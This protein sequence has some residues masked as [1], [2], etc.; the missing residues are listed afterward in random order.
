MIDDSGQSGKPMSNVC[1]FCGRRAYACR[2][3]PPEWEELEP[4]R[5]ACPS[6]FRILR[7]QRC[8]KGLEPYDCGTCPR[9]APKRQKKVPE[10]VTE[11]GW[12]QVLS[13]SSP[14]S[15]P[16]PEHAGRRDITEAVE[17]TQAAWVQRRQEC[18]HVVSVADLSRA[19]QGRPE[20]LPP[21]HPGYPARVDDVVERTC[22]IEGRS[23]EPCTVEPDPC[24]C[25]R[26]CDGPDPSCPEHGEPEPGDTVL[27]NRLL[28]HLTGR[29][30]D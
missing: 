10:S 12:S 1:A 28:G 9:C 23:V 30:R 19:Y 25:V 24:T 3:T 18:E 13:G 4:G 26:G 8:E 29:R 14:E 5:M 22:E 17:R 21:D 6:C 20:R 16:P 7:E 15:D 2:S 11:R 27:S